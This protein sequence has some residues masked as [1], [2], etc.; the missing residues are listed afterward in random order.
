MSVDIQ[1]HG[2]YYYHKFSESLSIKY[3]PAQLHETVNT[4]NTKFK[5]RGRW[6]KITYDTKV[7]LKLFNSDT[8]F[9]T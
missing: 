7:C 5:K 2:S 4:K 6:A 9:Y 3:T 1:D 8:L